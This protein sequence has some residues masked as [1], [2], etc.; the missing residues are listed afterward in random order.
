[1]AFITGSCLYLPANVTVLL[2]ELAD[3]LERGCNTAII[4]A[5]YAVHPTI[6]FKS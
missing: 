3:F 2:V 4:F 5:S 1:M 6:L